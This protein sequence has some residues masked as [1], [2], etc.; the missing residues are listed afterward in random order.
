MTISAR[1]CRVYA[2]KSYV[3]GTDP[4]VALKRRRRALAMAR[5]WAALAGGIDRDK[6]S[7]AS[8]Q[9]PIKR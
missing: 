9:I 5:S 1:K 6:A 4:T 2:K 3:L 7:E 8:R